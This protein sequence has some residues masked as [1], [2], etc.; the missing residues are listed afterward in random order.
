MA[1]LSRLGFLGIAAIFHLIY[2]SSIFD[3]YFVSP[4][5]HGM[6]AHRV[7]HEPPAKRV[8]L[9]VGKTL[10]SMLICSRRKTF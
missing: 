10:R 8:V 3:I 1:R 2:I 9:I 6:T 5:I 7:H 4:V